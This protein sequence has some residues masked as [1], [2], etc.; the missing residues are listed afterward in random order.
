M[1]V[2]SP[3]PHQKPCPTT[4]GSPPAL[5][6]MVTTAPAA[7]QF[8]PVALQARVEEIADELRV[9]VDLTRRVGR[10]D[11]AKAEI[12]APMITREVEAHRRQIDAA[13]GCQHR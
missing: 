1:T 9:V 6:A 13:L 7:L 11:A 4:K 2:S 12:L 10:G 5:L 3:P 8:V